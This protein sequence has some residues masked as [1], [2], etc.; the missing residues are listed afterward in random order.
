L[1][2]TQLLVAETAP[3]RDEF[4]TIDLIGRA[5]AGDVTRELYA[6]FLTQAYYHVRHTVPL[7]M[8]VGAHL[9]E[10]LRWLQAP[11][12]HYIEEEA[13][14]DEWILGDLEA[15]GV[16]ASAVRSGAPAVQTEAMV[17]YAYDFVA[18]RAPVGFFGMVHVLE[19][20]SSALALSAADSIQRAL[21]LP[22]RALTYLRTHGHLDQQHVEDFSS[23]VDRLDR[24]EDLPWIVECA[25]GIYWLYG[26][27]FRSLGQ[28]HVPHRDG[29]ARR[30]A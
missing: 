26:N 14:H 22:D 27:I 1:T 3:Q 10:R 6:G 23:I 16:D 20:T 21:G 18:R 28:V 2:N 11:I 15:L 24:A 12:V 8:A 4:R 7:L 25:R 5:L 30:C 17:A 13:G 9:P 29:L 19:G